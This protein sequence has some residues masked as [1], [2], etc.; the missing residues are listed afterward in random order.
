VVV[1]CELYVKSTLKTISEALPDA[2]TGELTIYPILLQS[3]LIIA[4]VL[5]ERHLSAQSKQE[6]QRLNEVA[7]RYRYE[8]AQARVAAETDLRQLHHDMKHHLLGLQQLAGDN[9][10]LERYIDQLLQRTKEYETLVDTGNPLLDGLL[11]EKIRQADRENIDLTV[12]VDIRQG[13]FL[14]DM[15]LCAIFGNA[16]DNAIEASRKVADPEKRSIL[17]KCSTVAKN[18]VLTVINY[19]EGTLNRSGDLFLSD[20]AA[21]GHGLGLASIRHTVEKYGGVLRAETDGYHNF[22]ITILIPISSET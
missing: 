12:M 9:E 5:L 4:L 10:K 3:L 7:T 6:Q 18:L 11:S 2:Y 20:K 1:I 16:L 17:V 8:S 19:Y 15:D 13:E 21:P 14:T 22:I